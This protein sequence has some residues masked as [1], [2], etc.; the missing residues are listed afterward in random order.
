LTRSIKPHTTF[1]AQVY[2]LSKEEGG[3]HRPFFSGYQPQFYLRTTDVTGVIRLPESID[4]VMP[5]DTVEIT[6]ELRRPIALEEGVKF[7]I[8]EGS[9]TV[10]AG[11]CTGIIA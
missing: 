7:A 1:K 3:R 10:G 4:M 11:F 6:V 9:R 8:C 5:G 2:A